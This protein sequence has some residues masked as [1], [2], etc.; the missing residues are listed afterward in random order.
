MANLLDKYGIKEV[1]DV[2][3]YKI[4][5]D[6][7]RGAPVLYLDTLKVST[8]EQTAENVAARG[9]KGNPELIIW[10]FNKEITLTLQDA[11]FSAKSLAMM[12]GSEEVNATTLVKTLAKDEVTS[13]GAKYYFTD[14]NGKKVELKQ[15]HWYKATG[16]EDTTTDHTDAVFVTGDVDITG[17]EFSI[18][19]QKFPDT[20][21]VTGDTYARSQAT[22]EDEYLQFIVQKA[23]MLS[24]VT[25]TM[26][27]EGDPAVFDMNLK[28]LRP[29]DG[30]MLKLVK[31]DF[32]DAAAAG[33]DG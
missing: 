13:E 7:R 6:G 14:M 29:A 22:G 11:L 25:L 24:E 31:Y 32:T 19:A 9:G 5:P 33:S 10:D 17:Y 16:E 27:A 4:N 3:F 30:K 2:V 20:Y 1:A 28:V 26:E 21:Y 18:D 15:P 23:K 12:F 8:I